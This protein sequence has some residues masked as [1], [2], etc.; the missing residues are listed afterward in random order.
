MW[1]QML[2]GTILNGKNF[3]FGERLKRTL[4]CGSLRWFANENWK[5]FCCFMEINGTE[6]FGLPK[7]QLNRLF[8]SL[9][10]DGEEDLT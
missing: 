7:L 2:I 4:N 9:K 6:D 5:K 10:L 8:Y 1:D 3:L